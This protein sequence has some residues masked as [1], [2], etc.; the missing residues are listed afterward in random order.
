MLSRLLAACLLLL[1]L[2]IAGGAEAPAVRRDLEYAKVGD[3]SLTLDLYVPEG[4]VRPPLIAWVHGG[5]WRAGSK[6]DM[7]LKALVAEGYA[8]AS[9]DYRLS[10]VAPFPAQAYDLKAAIRFLRARAGEYGLD[11]KNIAIAGGSA[12]GH[13]AALV[14]I[15]NGVKELEGAEGAYLTTSSDVQAIVSFYGASNL[16]S[17]LSQS[18]P[19]GLSVREPALRLLLGGLPDEKPDLAR[20]ASPV[21]HI[22]PGSPPLLLVHGD[23]DPQM[24][25]AQSLELRQ[26]Y[27]RAKLPVTLEVIEGGRHGGAEFYDEKRLALVMRFLADAIRHPRQP[28]PSHAEVPYGPARHQILDLYLPEAPERPSPVL[29]WFGGVWQA[30]KGAPALDRFLKAGVAVAAVETRTM[31]DAMR[32]GGAPPISFVMNDAARAV[33]FLRHH[34]ADWKLDPKRIAAGGSSQGALPALYLGCAGELA[35]TDAADPVERESTLIFGVGAHRSQP[36]IDPQRMQEWVPGVKWGAPAL[37]MSFEESLTRREEL[38]PLLR[39]W[40]PDAL[41]HRGAAPIYFE[42]NWPLT[43]PAGVAETDYKVHSPAWALGF[44]KLAEQAGV[45]CRVQ[46]PGHPV[47]GYKDVFDYLSQKLSSGSN[48]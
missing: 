1:T 30:G 36:S 2:A 29:V 4:Q 27:E 8:V 42:N 34:A 17:I 37:G 5:A 35:R 18:T 3:V 25:F 12:G 20:L 31:N 7:P 48:P 43:Q 24:P 23:A 45:E 33:Q 16:Q 22:R 39:K 40:S 13:L 44:Q 32:E 47:E 46:Y 10:T 11:G 6:T 38:Q 14:G 9:I 15:S 41:L 19:H 26:A 21:T 28:L